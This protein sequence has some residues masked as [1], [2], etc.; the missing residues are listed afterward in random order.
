M[1]LEA[2]LRAAIDASGAEMGL[3]MRH[4]ESDDAIDIDADRSLPLCSVLK[5][6]VLAEAFRQLRA[7]RFRLDD[8]WELTSAEKN[9]PSGVLVFFEDGLQPTVRDLLTLMI[10]IS[11]NTATDM[12]LHRLGTVAVNQFMHELGLT[13]TH[14]VLTIRDIFDDLL[15]SAD[16][17]QDLLALARQPRRRDGIA[18]STEPDNNV[19]TPRDMTRLL[20]L[21]FNG[22]VVDR[23]ACDEMLA[24]L[25]KQQLNDRL[26]RFL[27][28]GTPFAHKTGTLPGIRNDS[29][30]LYAGDASHVAVTVF[31]TWDD[32]AVVD[33]PVAE[34]ER[35]VAIDSAFGQIGRLIY[36]YYSS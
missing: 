24:I 20:S 30:I 18:Y 5:I 28:P 26:P 8:R 25:L 31:S 16:P 21:I 12:V 3:C 34:R 9:V 17:N 4:L 33:D 22:E 7:G 36:D 23:A 19:G 2:N 35:T 14:L 6:P 13:N 27:P 1:S 10:I 15:P 29:G 32:Q 11:D